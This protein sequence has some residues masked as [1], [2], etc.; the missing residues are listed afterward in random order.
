MRSTEVFVAGALLF[1]S[2]AEAF[3]PSLSLSGGRA[4]ASLAP[5]SSSSAGRGLLGL[6]MQEGDKYSKADIKRLEQNKDLSYLFEGNADWR[7]KKTKGDSG[8]FKD[9]AGGQTPKYLWIGCSDAR[10]AA[11]EI[12]GCEPGELFVHRNVAN[13]VVNND[14]SLQS[15]FQYAVEY[16]QVQHIIVC[17]HYQCGGVAASLNN[18]DLSSPLEEWVRNIRDV[19]RLH[20]AELDA[21]EDL[22]QRQRRMVELNAQEQALNV[23]KTAVVQRRRV[24]THLREGFATPK[25]HSVVFDIATGELTKLDWQANTAMS[26]VADKYDAVAQV[27]SATPEEKKV[28]EA[29][30][31]GEYPRRSTVTGTDTVTMKKPLPI[32]NRLPAGLSLGNEAASTEDGG[33]GWKSD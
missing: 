16:L 10:V 25:V 5:A 31:S 9:M 15:V 2:G 18:A 11:N 4:H 23:Y 13:L 26:K 7:A 14:N 27:A 28:L 21:I 22:T 1:V 24:Y 3:A 6:S 8:Y 12:V 30:V 19:Y 20:K 33:K 17:G 32:Y 29:S